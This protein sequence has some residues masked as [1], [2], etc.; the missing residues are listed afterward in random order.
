L[1][2]SGQLVHFLFENEI[3]KLEPKTAFYDWLYIHAVHRYATL[4][5]TITKY[6]GFTDIEF[7]PQKSINC[8]ARSCALYASLKQRGLLEDVLKDRTLFLNVLSRDSFYQPHSVGLKQG[9]LF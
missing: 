8:Q 3:W 1:K 2:A 4:S 9:K 7:N 5:E 6:V